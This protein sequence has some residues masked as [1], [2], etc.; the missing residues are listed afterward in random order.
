MSG[1]VSEP[2]Y[3]SNSSNISVGLRGLISFRI[4]PSIHA[5]QI[6]PAGGEFG[7]DRERE[8]GDMGVSGV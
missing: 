8:G 2:R 3:L 1:T 4:D 5:V 6:E 7:F